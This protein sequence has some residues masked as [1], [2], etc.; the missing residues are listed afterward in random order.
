[1]RKVREALH[2]IIW[3][4][5]HANKIDW[6][7][8]N[9]IPHHFTLLFITTC[10]YSNSTTLSH[11]VYLHGLKQLPESILVKTV[12]NS[13]QTHPA[14]VEAIMSS[15]C[16]NPQGNNNNIPRGYRNT[17]VCLYCTYSTITGIRE[18]SSIQMTVCVCKLP[19]TSRALTVMLKDSAS[20][21]V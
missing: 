12:H 15:H 2:D 14:A 7:R 9:S 4:V 1:M 8:D 17:K 16:F 18:T 20:Y 19:L 11:P 5:C 13:N 3:G 10:T 21:L 6:N